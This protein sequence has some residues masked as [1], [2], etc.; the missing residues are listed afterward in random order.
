MFAC[1]RAS[2]AAALAAAAGV[3]QSAGAVAEDVLGI[4]E[5]DASQVLIPSLL[6]A[7]SSVEAEVSRLKVEVG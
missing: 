7:A 4:G 2:A 6:P 1:A 5:V 3:A